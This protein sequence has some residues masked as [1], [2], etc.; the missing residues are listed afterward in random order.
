MSSQLSLAENFA[1]MNFLSSPYVAED[2]QWLRIAT[3]PLNANAISIFMGC[4]LMAM[5]ACAYFLEGGRAATFL[6][7]GGLMAGGMFVGLIFLVANSQRN[8]ILPH[9]DKNRE[10]L[11]LSSGTAIPKQEI[12]CFRQHI[13]RTK[14]SNFK[15]ILTT[16][17]T[18]ESSANAEY[19]VVP[20]IGNFSDDCVGEALAHFFGVKLIQNC[21]QTF[22]ANELTALGLS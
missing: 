3:R 4:T 2:E 15:L 12:V 10:L 22:S 19:A 1:G 17:V 16:V 13:C 20:V 8:A 21:E 14:T 7:V 6:M 9:I 18:N 11:V 5:V